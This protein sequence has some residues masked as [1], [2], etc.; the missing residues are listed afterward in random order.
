MHSVA[1][2]QRLNLGDLIYSRRKFD[3]ND[4]KVSGRGQS[5]EQLNVGGRIMS[6]GLVQGQRFTLQGCFAIC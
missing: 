2:A 1:S 3:E 4:P 5:S 6:E